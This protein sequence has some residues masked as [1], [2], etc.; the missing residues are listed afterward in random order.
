MYQQPL[1]YTYRELNEECGL[2]AEDLQK[3]AVIDFEFVDSDPI[4]EV[5]LFK[6]HKYT[7]KPVETEGRCVGF[8]C[9]CVSLYCDSCTVMLC[10]CSK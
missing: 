9:M 3:V 4:M 10:Q 6:T 2:I 5:H 1:L 8:C 7:G